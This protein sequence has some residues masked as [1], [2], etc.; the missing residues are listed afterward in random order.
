[1]IKIFV[2]NS[3]IKKIQENRER[4]KREKRV[5]YNTIILLDLHILQFL[6]DG[7]VS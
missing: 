7:Q 5:S 6:L 3:D 1:M 4:E 2:R